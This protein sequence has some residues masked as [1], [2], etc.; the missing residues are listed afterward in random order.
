MVT[1][2]RNS[3]VSHR[4]LTRGLIDGTGNGA[5]LTRSGKQLLALLTDDFPVVD[6]A[7]PES[8]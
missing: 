4:H 7:R 5:A 6:A 3:R 2:V 1:A 8:R